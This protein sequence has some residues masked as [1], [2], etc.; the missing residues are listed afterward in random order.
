MI[1]QKNQTKNFRIIT[2]FLQIDQKMKTKVDYF[3][4]SQIFNQ[5]E[6]CP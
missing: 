5:K 3:P 1:S 6:V 4:V 2:Q